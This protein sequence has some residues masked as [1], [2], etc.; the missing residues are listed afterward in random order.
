MKNNKLLL[1]IYISI[2][3]II[4]FI[5]IFL[6]ILGNKT[7]IGYLSEFKID[8]DDTLEINGLNIEETKQVFTTENKLEYDS[9]SNYIFTNNYITNYSYNFIIKYYNKAFRNSDI[10]G[11]YI[12]TNKIK[13]AK[14]T[15]NRTPLIG[16]YLSA[17]WIPNIPFIFEKKHNIKNV[18]IKYI[19]KYPINYIKHKIRIAK[20][21]ITIKENGYKLDV[22]TV[23]S[24]T[25]HLLSSS[26]KEPFDI[27]KITFSRLQYKI[28]DFFYKYLLNIPVFCFLI[29]SLILFIITFLLLIC[30]KIKNYIL[31]FS[32]STSISVIV[33]FITV[34]IFVTMGVYKYIYP[35]VA[36]SIISLLGL[37]AFIYEKGG[38]KK[39]ISC[40][41]NKG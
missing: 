8:I 31:L 10:Y 11:V 21:F 15:Y 35:I 34:F 14:E 17:R 28:Y 9:I 41:E 3:A 6:F 33:T 25:N 27:N 30:K 13:D 37:I 16:D 4:V 40:L 7:R 36:I 12:D 22:N 23:Q 1:K 20:E 38:I 2:S 24:E 18:W 26:V 39:L 29:L 5:F 19:L 32:F